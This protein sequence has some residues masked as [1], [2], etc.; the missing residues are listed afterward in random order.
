M[1]RQGT[2][3]PQ[4]VTNRKRAG[5]QKGGGKQGEQCQLHIAL[6]NLRAADGSGML[7]GH[8]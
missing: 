1:K 6:S 8:G 3:L 2:K 7:D 4:A 5:K